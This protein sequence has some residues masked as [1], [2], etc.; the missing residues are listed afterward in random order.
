MFAAKARASNQT[1]IAAQFMY[2]KDIPRGSTASPAASKVD[3]ITMPTIGV[4]LRVKYV[5][6]W[7]VNNPNSLATERAM[8]AAIQTYPGAMLNNNAMSPLESADRM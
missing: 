7:S 5:V 4:N 6:K 2:S 8:H 3:Q 1:S